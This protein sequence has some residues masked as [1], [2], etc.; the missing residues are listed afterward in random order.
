MRPAHGIGTVPIELRFTLSFIVL[1]CNQQASW[2][3]LLW[4]ILLCHTFALASQ[5][6]NI[7]LRRKLKDRRHKKGKLCQGN[8]AGHLSQTHHTAF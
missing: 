1:S 6:V 4:D 3:E 5:N 8:Y 7:Q 2:V